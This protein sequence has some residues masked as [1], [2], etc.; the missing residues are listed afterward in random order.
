LAIT[1][2]T[3]ELEKPD[4][5]TPNRPSQTQTGTRRN[6]PTL[7]EDQRDLPCGAQHAVTPRQPNLIAPT[8]QL[9]IPSLPR[10]ARGPGPGFGL[11]S[12]LIHRYQASSSVREPR[13]PMAQALWR[14]PLLS[15]RRRRSNPIAR[16]AASQVTPR[17]TARLDCADIATQHSFAGLVPPCQLSTSNPPPSHHEHRPRRPA[18]APVVS[19]PRRVH[20]PHVTS[21]RTC[22]PAP[23]PCQLSTSTPPPS[24]H[25]H[26]PR[27]P[28]PA[29]APPGPPPRYGGQPAA[30]PSPQRAAPS[31]PARAPAAAR[32]APRSGATRAPGP[33]GARARRRRPA[34]A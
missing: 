7:V 20:R 13:G 1:D 6:S 14:G 31:A 28:A 18:P 12:G 16:G 26:R 19:S 29:P 32:R 8:S 11:R 21:N 23:A 2:Y 9:S 4:Q 22:R 17:A 30:P 25:E 27:R 15:S 10:T 24:H 34:A 3:H 33:R 5:N